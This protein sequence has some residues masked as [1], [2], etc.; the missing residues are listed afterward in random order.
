MLP[1]FAIDFISFHIRQQMSSNLSTDLHEWIESYEGTHF[2][3]RH[4][5]RLSP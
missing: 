2:S 4:Q 3:I 1:P 5:V